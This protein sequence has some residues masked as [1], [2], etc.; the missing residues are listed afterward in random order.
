MMLGQTMT[1][2]V[3]GRQVVSH[4]FIEQNE[5]EQLELSLELAPGR[6][7]IEIRYSRWREIDEND[8]RPLAVLFRTLLVTENDGVE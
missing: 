6:H 8:N 7:L 4:E 2:L 5:F 1:V 3:S